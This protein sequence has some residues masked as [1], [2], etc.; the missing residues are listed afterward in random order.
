M[1]SG[2]GANGQWDELD[3][4]KRM[5]GRRTKAGH[6]RPSARHSGT[7]AQRHCRLRHSGTAAQPAASGAIVDLLA[8]GLES[9]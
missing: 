1:G 2:A 8:Q 4:G 7:A 9:G 5:K 6:A 3:D